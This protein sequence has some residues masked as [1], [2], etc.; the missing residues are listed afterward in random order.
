MPGL[1][2]E[3]AH[4]GRGCLRVV[5][6]ADHDD[7]NRDRVRA[8]PRPTPLTAEFT[9]RP[10]MGVQPPLVGASRP[11]V[12]PG[13]PVLADQVGKVLGV[14]P[15]QEQE[16][17]Q[18][19]S[20][21]NPP[22]S[23]ACRAR[24]PALARCAAVGSSQRGP[25]PPRRTTRLGHRRRGSVAASLTPR[26]GHGPVSRGGENPVRL[27]RAPWGALARRGQATIGLVGAPTRVGT[28]GA[29]GRRRRVSRSSGTDRARARPC[30]TQGSSG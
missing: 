4:R 19:A 22:G 18:V 10:P 26:I 16:P 8:P 1:V 17:N 7:P 29:L 15:R 2:P 24:A 28:R 21:E 14:S 9:A 5:T 3:G 25:R 13:R 11:A 30:R 23:A 20:R 6:G 27:P 12:S